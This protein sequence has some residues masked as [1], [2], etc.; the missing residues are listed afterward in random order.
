[1]GH[2][3]S[4]EEEY[5]PMATTSVPSTSAQGASSAT[6]TVTNPF[7]SV[8]HLIDDNL[9]DGVERVYST[10]EAARFFDKSNQWLYWGMRNGIFTYPPDTPLSVDDVVI[11][12]Q[13]SARGKVTAIS[14][15]TLTVVWDASS[16]EYEVDPSEVF[17]LITP[18]RIGK[19]GR[20]RFTLP[21]IRDI[22][23][24]CYWRGN[25]SED[26]YWAVRAESTDP[27]NGSVRKE[28]WRY[29]SPEEAEMA[30][31][32]LVEGN[33]SVEANIVHCIGLRQILARIV[34]A[35]R[36]EY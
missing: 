21:V 36:G 6:I 13:T 23:L 14:Q 12:R 30:R 28:S 10:S 15:K 26:Q 29:N 32:E 31:K 11:H 18:E 34:A 8:Q 7:S 5:V 4:P 33:S 19:G 20:R 25:L 2:F 3:W 35:Q 9:L 1:M 22:A 17:K 24:S 27:E 16:L